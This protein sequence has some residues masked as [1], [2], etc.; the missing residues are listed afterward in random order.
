M[1]WVDEKPLG[2]QSPLLWRAQRARL[3]VLGFNI[4]LC[5]KWKVWDQNHY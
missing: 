4:F 5:P 1:I 2:N 3:K